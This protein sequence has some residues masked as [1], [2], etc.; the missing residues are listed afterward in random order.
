MLWKGCTLENSTPKSG[1]DLESL[2]CDTLD[3]ELVEFK[4]SDFLCL[5]VKI[6]TI[7]DK[8]NS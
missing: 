7:L 6:I 3:L 4:S 1:H 5:K 8:L 2:V